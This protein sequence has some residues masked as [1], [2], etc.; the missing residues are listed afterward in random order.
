MPT[1][2]NL[3]GLGQEALAEF[4][5]ELGEKS[6]R[7]QQIMGWLYQRGVLRFRDMT[8]ISLRVRRQLDLIATLELPDVIRVEKST[9]GTRKW[10]LDVGAGQAVEAVFI[11]EPNR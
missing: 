1:K 8:D 6:Y 2:L 11:P 5:E 10:L 3:I 7:A 4:F 9:D